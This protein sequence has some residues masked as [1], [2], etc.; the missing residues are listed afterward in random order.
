ERRP[1]GGAD[2]VVICA[3]GLQ[4][5]SLQGGGTHVRRQ[6]MSFQPTRRRLLAASALAAAGIV[7]DDALAEPLAP[8]PQ[9]HDGDA[10][11]Q[12]QTEGPY[13][14]PTPPDAAPP[15]DPT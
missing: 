8:T 7:L 4:R 12:R 13:F 10:P 3:S 14:K 9:C 15:L 5:I 11:T 6:V 2:A 1:G